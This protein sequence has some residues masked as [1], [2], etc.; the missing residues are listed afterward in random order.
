MSEIPMEE[1]ARQI[2]AAA[3]AEDQDS[4]RAQVWFLLGEFG[5]KWRQEGRR[6]LLQQIASLK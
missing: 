1:Y 3:K 6:E 4:G 5:E 2:I